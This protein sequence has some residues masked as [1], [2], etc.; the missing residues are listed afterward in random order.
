[1]DGACQTGGH[2]TEEGVCIV[3]EPS[4]CVCSGVEGTGVLN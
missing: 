3:M 4:A 1:M 2:V